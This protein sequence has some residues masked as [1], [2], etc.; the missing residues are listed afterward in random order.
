MS[1]RF[2][3]LIGFSVVMNVVLVVILTGM[4]TNLQGEVAGLKN[5][6]AT[7]QDLAAVSAPRME[8]FEQRKCT[9]CHSE[10]RFAGPHRT[11]EEEI[12]QALEHMRRLPDTGLTDRD[13]AR[14]HA[15]LDLLRCASCH[16]E[17]KLRVL[18]LKT[19]AERREVV[20]RMIAQPGSKIG[21]DEA[22][23]ILRA[24]EELVGF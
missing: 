2:K 3:F 13:M 10:R 9:T 17:E 24:Y 7:K 15:S 19:P 14:I 23:H 1:T 16:G 12:V 18:A 11:Q 8:Q 4:V 20:R 6:L 5:V 22:E 21:P